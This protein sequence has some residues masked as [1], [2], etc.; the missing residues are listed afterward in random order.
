[1]RC[2]YCDSERVELVSA[3]GG[4]I[5]T[6]QV[7]CQSCGTYFEALRE[8]FE[9]RTQSETGGSRECATS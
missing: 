9:A 8:D 7:R 4:Q 5:I 3:W 2:P 1:M 6:S